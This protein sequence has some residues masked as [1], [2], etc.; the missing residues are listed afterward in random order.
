M[1]IKIVL[2]LCIASLLLALLTACHSD[3]TSIRPNHDSNMALI[4]KEPTII[5][6]KYGVAYAGSIWIERGFIKQIG[7][8]ADMSQDPSIRVIDGRGKFIIPGLFDMH[9]HLVEDH[10]AVP[11]LGHLLA[12]GITG[13]RDLGG[14]AESVALA[15]Q[16]I[17][18]GEMTGPDVYFSGWT[19]DG[20]QAADP[21]HHKIQSHDDINDA[22]Q[23]LGAMGVDFFKIHNYFPREQLYNLKRISDQL[24]LKIIGHIPVG[25]G[26]MEL[27]AVGIQG[28]EHI[29]SVLS[30]IVLDPS[31]EVNTLADALTALNESYVASWAVYLRQNGIALTPT[32]YAMDDMYS[33]FEGEA[34]QATG[35]RLMALFHDMIR[36]LNEAGVVLLAGTD[37]GVLTAENMDQLHEE[38]NH[39]VKAGLSP[40]DALKTATI[41]PAMFLELDH[42]HGSID[43]NKKANLVILHSNPLIDI[44]NTRDIHLV[45]KNGQ[46]IQPTSG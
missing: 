40:A 30:G 8:L 3:Q 25:I 36:W 15:R 34:A 28:I 31:N 41:N 17:A 46:V 21:F 44:A 4:I 9:L 2:N 13:V 37:R 22:V 29:N 16:G 5:D 43:I 38:L 6:V 42:Q 1:N 33:N 26:L 19:L 12:R 45:L 32:L 39:L 7:P 27:D 11:Q 14:V 24:G 18:R 10:N 20:N 35:R 23:K